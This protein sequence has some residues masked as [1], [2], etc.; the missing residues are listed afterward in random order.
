[1]PHSVELSDCDLMYYH[2]SHILNI[3]LHCSQQSAIF[4][5]AWLFVWRRL[6]D[7][8]QS[9]VS[10]T[11]WPLWYDTD[12][13]VF[14]VLHVLKLNDCCRGVGCEVW[15]IHVKLAFF[16]CVSETWCICLYSFSYLFPLSS[17][18]IC[19]KL[20]CAPPTSAARWHL[21]ISST[22]RSTSTSVSWALASLSSCSASFSAATCS[23]TTQQTGLSV[24]PQHWTS[25]SMLLKIIQTNPSCPDR[26]HSKLSA[27]TC[28]EV[29][30]LASKSNSLFMCQ[31]SLT[32]NLF[33]WALLFF[34]SPPLLLHYLLFSLRDQ[35]ANL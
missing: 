19:V 5:T 10:L 28:T 30:R 26:H 3:H 2:C 18:G 29:P 25:I 22:C 21:R 16:K 9:R 1:M 7:S 24:R 20:A 33:Q 12:A 17:Q 32:C 35:R 11:H 14:S 15:Y 27:V 13:L 23:G 6:I 31:L 8:N 4:M 34:S